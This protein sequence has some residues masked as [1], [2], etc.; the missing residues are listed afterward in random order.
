MKPNLF[1]YKALNT[2]GEMT[3]GFIKGESEAQAIL[4]LRNLGMYPTQI[5]IVKDHPYDEKILAATPKVKKPFKF[6]PTLA[7]VVGVI[8]GSVVTYLSILLLL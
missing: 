6:S 4:N 1:S 7:F 8:A 2:R 3:E 5:K